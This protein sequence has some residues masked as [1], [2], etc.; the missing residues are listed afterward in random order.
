MIATK[1]GQAIRFKEKDTI[2]PTASAIS[3]MD[4]KTMKMES[5]R[6]GEIEIAQYIIS[7]FAYNASLP[8]LF[9]PKITNGGTSLLYK[10]ADS[11]QIETAKMIETKNGMLNV[12]FNDSNPNGIGYQN[13]IQVP[14]ELLNNHII[15]YQQNN[16][17]YNQP[18]YI[19]SSE[20]MNG[21]YNVEKVGERFI[22]TRTEEPV[23]VMTMTIK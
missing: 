7:N 16:G 22:L 21:N 14:Q 23:I 15:T 8:T 4:N 11:W 1:A 19:C 12:Q 3:Q 17:G 2:A 9:E 20:V 10:T 13:Q 18:Y 5:I 6:V